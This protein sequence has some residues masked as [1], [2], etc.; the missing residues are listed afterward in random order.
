M[1]KPLTFKGDKPKKRKHTSTSTTTTDGSHPSKKQST[2]TSLTTQQED[3]SA[4]EHHDENTLSDQ[5]WVSADTSSDISGPILLI[6]R[7]T[8]PTCLATDA[9]GTV[10]ASPLE[11]MIEGDPRTA[12]PHDVR[13]VWIA[14][15]IAG[16][17]GWSLKGS[18]GRYLT[19][20]KHGIMSANASAISQHEIYTINESGVG[21]GG[22]FVFGT[23][24]GASS[25]SAAQGGDGVDDKE[26]KEKKQTYIVARTVTSKTTASGTKVEV[27]GDETN[28]D[29]GEEG[30]GGTNIRVRMQARFKP[31]IQASKEIKARE[32]IGRKELEGIVGRRLDDDEVKR[33]RKARKE[34]D[35]HEVVLDVRVRGKHDKFA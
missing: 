1:V 4:T 34:G 7:T 35:F 2:S 27:R 21:G 16:I 11:N 26:K 19:S 22:F 8:P 30:G 24:T 3:P 29:D 20:D 33:L 15:K 18:N 9:H 17:E 31:R 32:K 13:Q 28:L 23:G 10:F 25:S 6:L 14:S 5:S 12:E